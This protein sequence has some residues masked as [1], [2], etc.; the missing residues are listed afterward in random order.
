MMRHVNTLG[1]A[2]ISVLAACTG[3]IGDGETEVS[4]EALLAGTSGLRRL[5]SHEYDNTVRDVLDDDTR[6]SALLLP[7]DLLNPFDNDFTT[8]R[9]SQALIEGAEQLATEAAERLLADPPRRDLVVGCTPSAPDDPCLEQFVTRFGR[10]VLRRAMDREEIDRYVTTARA[11][12]VAQNDFYA[13]VDVVLRALMQDPR[14]L[15]RVELGTPV[16]GESGLV[17]LD[18]MSVAQRLSYLA[19]GSAPDAWMLDLAEA[20]ELRTAAQLEAAARRALDDP[21]ARVQIR[22]FHALWLGYE[23]LPHEAELATAMRIESDA[24]VERVIF[25]DKGAW[26]D[27]F[28]ATDTFVSDSLATHYGLTPSGSGIAAWTSYGDSG[29]RG[30][31]SH[32]SFL[33]NGAKF[34][35]TSPTIRG[36]AIRTRLFCAEIPPPPPGVKT[37]EPIPTTEEAKC[38]VDRYAQHAQ[39]GCANC[40]SQI[41]PIGF[42]LENYDAQGRYRETEAG[43]P[44]CVIEGVGRVE[45][46]GSFHGPAELTDLML[47]SPDFQRC[48]VTQLQ[49]FASGRY[50]LDSRDKGRVRSHVDALG[51]D[52]R[53]DDLLVALVAHDAFRYRREQ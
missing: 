14:F 21:R 43:L 17:A 41:D 18:P 29:R 22:R 8:Q 7:S 23:T 34:G 2:V 33:S 24:L 31:L 53:F 39:G 46:L 25:E 20:G 35:D 50:E 10:L 16:E 5:T 13:G 28:R 4:A 42:G 1:A 11:I 44:E 51:A 38:K 45:P 12:A 6:G 3:V 27:I 49:R 40:H 36:L 15:Y 48:A 32:G 26:Q 37:D 30:I 9:V 47:E 19:W 52:Y